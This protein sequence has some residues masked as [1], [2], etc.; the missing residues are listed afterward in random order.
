MCDSLKVF[1][2]LQLLVS[3]PE[4]D[5]MVLFCIRCS[6]RIPPT[7]CRISVRHEAKAASVSYAL[8]SLLSP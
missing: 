1:E 5:F 7:L 2:S 4:H 8:H 3:Q 6:C